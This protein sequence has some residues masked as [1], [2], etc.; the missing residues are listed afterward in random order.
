MILEEGEALISL[1]RIPV[2]SKGPAKRSKIFYNPAM[3]NNRSICT[4]V[5]RA[6]GIKSFLDGFA[7]TGVRGIR[8]IKE[9]GS[10]VI[11][12][13]CE[14]EAFFAIKKNLELNSIEADVLNED[15]CAL[16]NSAELCDID[17]FGTPEPFLSKGLELSERFLAVTAT[18]TAVLFGSNAK[19]CYERYGTKVKKVSWSKELG[20]R[21]LC[22]TVAE[23]AKALG[24]RVKPLFVYAEDHYLRGYFEICDCEEE[25]TQIDGMGPIWSGKLNDKEILKKAL[26]ISKK[27]EYA[28]KNFVEKLFLKAL[29]EV[30]TIGYYDVDCLSSKFR[31]EEPKLQVLVERLQEQGFQA[32]RTIFS[33][34]GIKTDAPLNELERAFEG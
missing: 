24:K 21:V 2:T 1:P 6:L 23:K 22:Y 19:K 8:V 27:K 26:E 30:D 13:D 4:L 12:N 11:F 7:A 18:D 34:K 10:E 5:C 28:G 25:I 32:S 20:A 14:R 17:P 31:S 9:A 33:P 16:K 3:R 15:F 29:D